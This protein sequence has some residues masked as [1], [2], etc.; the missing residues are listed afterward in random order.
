MI[1]VVG[2]RFF[3]LL[4]PKERDTVYEKKAISFLKKN[5]DVLSPYARP[6]PPDF[7]DPETPWHK[8]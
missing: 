1:D 8:S 6:E 7:S 4:T 5:K 3:F 2:C